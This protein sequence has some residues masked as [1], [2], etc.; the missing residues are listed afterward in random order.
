MNR[1]IPIL[2]LTLLSACGQGSTES[3]PSGPSELLA[4]LNRV[5]NENAVQAQRTWGNKSVVVGGSMNMAGK[6]P[7]GTLSVLLY[8]GSGTSVAEL[9]FDARYADWVAKLEKDDA[10]LASCKV[11]PEFEGISGARLI[12]CSPEQT[13]KS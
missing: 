8:P 5:Y 6:N 11:D 3:S 2:C 4:K 12:A 9:V 7:D 10:L 1:I 13:K